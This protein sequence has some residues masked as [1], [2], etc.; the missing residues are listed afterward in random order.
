MSN[1]KRGNTCVVKTITRNNFAVECSARRALQ[2]GPRNSNRVWNTN[3]QKSNNPGTRRLELMVV[4]LTKSPSRKFIPHLM[5][6]NHMIV[7]HATYHLFT[8]QWTPIMLPLHLLQLI[9]CN[10]TMTSVHMAP[11]HMAPVY[12]S[13]V[14]MSSVHMKCG[15][16][17]EISQ[18]LPKTPLCQ[19][20]MATIKNSPLMWMFVMGTLNPQTPLLLPELI[21]LPLMWIL[22]TME[23]WM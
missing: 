8:A 11:V 7:L 12:M 23:G 10:A 5:V 4:V 14:H 20:L 3:Y 19:W 18:Y 17:A 13:T 15:K 22:F 9:L 16:V 2:T 6:T 1:C 21:P